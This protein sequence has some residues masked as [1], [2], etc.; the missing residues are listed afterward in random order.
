M[1]SLFKDLIND[2]REIPKGL[3]DSS[4][5]PVT[6]LQYLMCVI[7]VGIL[8]SVC[9]ALLYFGVDIVGNVATYA[10]RGVMI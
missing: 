1:V 2:L 5:I 6:L 7:N 4:L 3:T 9:F 8:I 10:M